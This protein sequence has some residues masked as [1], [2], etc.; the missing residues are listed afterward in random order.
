[1]NLNYTVQDLKCGINFCEDKEAPDIVNEIKKNFSDKK[2][3]LVIDDK[4]SE[5]FLKY[6]YKDLGKLNL[7]INLLKIEAT[8]KNK[9]QQ[10][11]FKIIDKLIKDKFTKKS[12]LISCGGG[13]VGDVCALASSL[14]LRGLIY[15]H[16]P[17]TMT[18]IV[19]SCIGG[20]TGINYKNII[21]SVGNYYHPKRVFISKNVINLI[22]KREF[23]SGV[24][25]IIKSGLIKDYEII[26]LL[27]ENKK[28]FFN[29]DYRFLKKLISKTL[30]TKIFF[31]K[32]D[33]FENSKRLNLNFGHTFAHAIEMTFKSTKGDIIRHGEAVGIGMLC[34]IYY[35]EGKSKIFD[36]VK[37]L[38]E[39]Y[40]LPTNILNISK[41]RNKK[42]IINSIYKNIFLDKKRIGKFPRIISIKKINSPKI[43]EMKSLEKIKKTIIKVLFNTVK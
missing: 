5:K 26:K 21:N 32:N 42:Q 13:V 18:A 24:P 40:G 4:L 10:V 9:N 29:R 16:I 39:I 3:L 35:N 1:M 11:L 28:N 14:Y 12:V 22:P 19:D 30:K 23:I 37:N 6:L 41:S 25:E 36:L 7:K 17:T 34:E 38:L 31:F 8:K 43:V 2:L 15:Y 20:K 33:V 27:S